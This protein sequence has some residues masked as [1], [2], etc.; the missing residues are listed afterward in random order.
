MTALANGSGG[1]IFFMNPDANNL[2]HKTFERFKERFVAQVNKATSLS[3]NLM[4]VVHVKLAFGEITTW[5]AV[6]LKKSPGKLMYP[7]LQVQGL[8]KP[9]EFRVG[10]S[11][12]VCVALH[13]EDHTPMPLPSHIPSVEATEMQPTHMAGDADGRTPAIGSSPL[14]EHMAEQTVSDKEKDDVSNRV[15]FRSCTRLNWSEN[16]KDWRK[17]VNVKALDTDDIVGSSPMWDATHPMMVTPNRSIVQ[18]LFESERDMKSILTQVETR[19]PGFAIVCKTWGFHVSDNDTDAAIPAGHICDILTVTSSGRIC[20]WV[21]VDDRSWGN[22]MNQME[23]MMTTGRMLKYKLLMKSVDADLSEV[24]IACAMTS[25]SGVPDSRRSALEETQ[26]MQRHLSHFYEGEVQLNSLKL[27]L[28]MVVLS[29]ES[30]LKRSVADHTSIVLSEQQAEVLMHKAKVNYISGPAGSGKSWTASCLYKMYGKHKSVYMCTTKA[31]VAYLA[32][33]DCVGTLVRCDQDLLK[34]IE[35]G[36]FSSKT[37]VIIDDSHNFLC[38]KSS[39]KKLFQLLKSNREMS[40]FVFAD[41]D[42]QSFNRDRQQRVHDCIYKLTREVLRQYPVELRLTEI[43]RNTKQ[44]VSFVQCAIQ[45]TYDGHQKIVCANPENGDGV[46]CIRVGNLWTD[47]PD[48]DLVLYVLSLLVSKTY[49]PSEIAILLDPS[50]TVEEIEQCHRILEQ[51]IPDLGIQ[52]AD[53]FPRTCLVLDTVDSFLGLDA[54]L[55]VFILSDY[56]NKSKEK[57]NML[58]KLFRWWD[59]GPEMSIN[60]PYYRVFLASRATHK[61]VFVVPAIDPNIVQQMKFDYFQVRIHK[62][63]ISRYVYI[64]IRIHNTIYSII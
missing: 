36:T 33:N 41:N 50:Y 6:L 13:L 8:W 44:V 18:H 32:S 20:F 4:D 23:Y 49:H 40:L 29:R 5:A 11:G 56:T 28:A 60:S 48:N 7:H 43:H 10:L 30:P 3:P 9:T 46:E 47:G 62:V 61:A 38:T 21:I 19:E 26:T 17:Y 51:N 42:Y 45:D 52:K 63:L 34:Q 24:Y 53:A 35:D 16:K 27:A 1:V 64:Y 25:P 57:K 59:P 39:L 22:S 12:Q 2:D 14:A 54:A 15:D 31:F 58:Q 55:C 37:C